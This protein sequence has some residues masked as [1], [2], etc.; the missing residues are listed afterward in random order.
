MYNTLPTPSAILN[1]VI[2][3]LIIELI[4]DNKSPLRTSRT[5]FVIETPGTNGIIQPTIILF[6]SNA[7]FNTPKIFNVSIVSNVINATVMYVFTN[8][9]FS[10]CWK[11][12]NTSI[13]SIDIKKATIGSIIPPT[14]K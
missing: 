13:S 6:M 5:E 3:A 4:P 8:C 14:S 9:G 10:F 11:N 1:A 12:L 2:I 7:T